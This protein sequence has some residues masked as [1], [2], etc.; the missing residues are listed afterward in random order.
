VDDKK[1]AGLMM[2]LAALQKFMSKGTVW[3]TGRRYRNKYNSY[4]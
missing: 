2:M 3:V 4:I 1:M